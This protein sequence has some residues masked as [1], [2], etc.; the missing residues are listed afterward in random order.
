MAKKIFLTVVLT[1][2]AMMVGTDISHAAPEKTVEPLPTSAIE[3][4][5][6][7]FSPELPEDTLGNVEDGEEI[8]NEIK[9]SE[10]PWLDIERL[11]DRDAYSL[12]AYVNTLPTPQGKV[13]YPGEGS[14][15]FMA[16]NEKIACVRQVGALNCSKANALA[17]KAQRDADYRFPGRMHNGGPGDAFRHCWWSASMTTDISES[18]AKIVGDNHEKYVSKDSY[19]PEDREMDLFNNAQGRWAAV[20]SNFKW[21]EAVEL[22]D[23]WTNNGILRVNNP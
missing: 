5:I 4:E 10:N 11:S 18:V 8:F 22:C 23:S 13:R 17:Q 2:I 20:A 12:L 15:F 21:Q 19:S 9:Y 1:S 16:L 6:A 7:S 14:D 3:R